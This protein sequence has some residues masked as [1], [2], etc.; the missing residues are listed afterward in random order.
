M[1]RRDFIQVTAGGS[2]M[3]LVPSLLN[4]C[5]ETPSRALE[6]WQGHPEGET[7]IRL[8]V[9]SY[10]ILAPNPHNKQPWIV[11]MRGALE[12]DLYVDPER[13]LPET[14]PP[15]RQI[16]IGHGT[17]LENLELAARHFGYRADIRYFPAGMYANTVVEPKPVASI[18]LVRD[19]SVHRD[20]LFDQILAR[21]SN[22]REYEDAPLSRQQV[23]GLMSSYDSSRYKLAITADSQKRAALSEIAIKAMEIEVGNRERDLESLAMFRFNDEEIE[24]YR[25][26]FGVAHTGASGLKKWIAETFFLSRNAAEKDPSEFGKAVIPITIKQ[27]QSAAAYGWIVS[28]T[29]LRRDQVEVGRAYERVNLAATALGVAVHPLSQVLQEYSDMSDLQQEFK[30]FL[31]VPDGH[32]VQMF[33]RLGRARPIQHSPRREISSLVREAQELV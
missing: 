11:D 9:L 2:A 4:G 15:F 24:H 29:N 18:T 21:Q 25:D 14:D 30:T 5:A 10:A 28:K 13:L 19:A 31:G 6:A 22:K 8:L 27:A 17:F 7:D 3:L 23:D 32:T 12:F 16:H 20:P 1:N 33:F 26:G